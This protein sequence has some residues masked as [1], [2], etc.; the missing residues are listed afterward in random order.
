[1]K[2]NLS[3]LVLLFVLI[4]TVLADDGCPPGAI[5]YDGCPPRAMCRTAD[6]SEP[7][8]FS[9]LLLVKDLWQSLP[10]VF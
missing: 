1:M 10:H 8:G 4:F 5:C 6:Q 9:A 3:V 7:K 2:K